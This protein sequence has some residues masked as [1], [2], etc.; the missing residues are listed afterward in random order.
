MS[1]II[2]VFNLTWGEKNEEDITSEDITINTIVDPKTQGSAKLICKQSGVIAGL[3]V[4]RLVFELLDPLVRFETEFKDGDLVEMGTL[5][6]T[7]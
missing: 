7:V 4:F 3:D 5:V 2:R 1:P 6:R